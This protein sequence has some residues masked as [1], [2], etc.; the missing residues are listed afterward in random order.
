MGVGREATFIGLQG[1]EG[2]RRICTE[3]CFSTAFLTLKKHSLQIVQ[4]MLPKRKT[5]SGSHDW[6]PAMSPLFLFKAPRRGT[7]LLIGGPISMFKEVKGDHSAS[8]L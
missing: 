2:M 6:L 3:Q 8:R 1:G 7:K 4:K 5:V